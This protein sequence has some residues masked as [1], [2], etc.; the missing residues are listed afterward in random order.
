MNVEAWE[1]AGK[2]LRDAA[3]VTT[4]KYPR[5]IERLQWLWESPTECKQYL[6]HTLLNE[7]EGHQGFPVEVMD[8]IMRIEKYYLKLHPFD[9][10]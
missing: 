6:Q 9:F 5:V 10:I 8:E 4:S 2:M 3:P 7:A 1:A